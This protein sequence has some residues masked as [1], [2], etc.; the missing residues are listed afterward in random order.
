LQHAVGCKKSGLVIFWH[1]KIREELI[2]LAG[3]ALTL[4]AFRDEPLICPCRAAKN[5]NTCQTNQTS[6]KPASKDKQGDILP[7]SLPWTSE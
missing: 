6:K 2:H 7:R 3:K 5:V 1:N 4:S